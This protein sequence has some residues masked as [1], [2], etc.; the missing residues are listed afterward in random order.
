[1]K[2]TI[3]KVQA[4]VNALSNLNNSIEAYTESAQN[5]IDYYESEI[6]KRTKDLQ[7]IHI[8]A[9]SEELADIIR[10]D[11]MLSDYRARLEN[12]TL[13]LGAYEE[14]QSTLIKLL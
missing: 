3:K 8:D 12:A 10:N 14:I 11:W 4:M 7:E 1:M 6:A 13:Q 9:D 5:D 2:K